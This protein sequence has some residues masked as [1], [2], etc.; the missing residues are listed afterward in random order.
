MKRRVVLLALVTLGS[1][2][3][4]A[5]TAAVAQSSASYKLEEQVLNA[6]GHPINGNTMNSSHFRMT[7]DS[8]G[9]AVVGVG[10]GSASYAVDSGFDSAYPPPGEIAGMWFSDHDTMHWQAEP[11]A[12]S[13]NLYRDLMSNLS[14]LGYGQ[15]F[16]ST[17]SGTSGT[18]TGTPPV[19]DGW[20]Y[21]VTADNRLGEE[22]T[23]GQD[24][25]ATE[26]QGTV[27]P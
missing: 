12:G 8:I 23:K 17:V 25:A 16:D 10:I 2:A 7:L 1:L 15:C 4:F 6:G 13:Y 18:D 9:E 21:L 14:G 24:S 19:S 26:R 3:G 27:C 5:A 11:S 20:F 22:G